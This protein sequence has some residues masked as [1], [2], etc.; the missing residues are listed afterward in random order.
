MARNSLVSVI[1]S[2]AQSRTCAK[3]LKQ[4][5]ECYVVKYV[6]MLLNFRL[7]FM[8]AL[9]RILNCT[10]FTHSVWYL[11]QAYNLGQINTFMKYEII[12]LV[13]KPLI[14][15]IFNSQLYNAEH[16]GALTLKTFER[17]KLIPFITSFS[18]FRR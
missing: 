18:R 13:L 12:L 1:A 4:T 6:N 7:K 2:H 17:P 8:K 10:V 5:G 14:Y 11:F 3:Y 9:E 16:K 15:S